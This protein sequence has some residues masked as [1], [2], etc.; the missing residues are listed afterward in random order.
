MDPDPQLDPSHLQALFSSG[1]HS[2]QRGDSV[3]A[4]E[5]L[6]TARLQAP[7][8]PMVP[9]T[10]G[11]VSSRVRAARPGGERDHRHF[12]DQSVLSARPAG[13]GRVLPEEPQVQGGGEGISGHFESP[14][15]E[16]QWPTALRLRLQ[17][18]RQAVRRDTE[19]LAEY[20]GDRV[21]GLSNELCN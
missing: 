6:E 14:P 11:R 5:L 18:A 7:R 9:L 10:I 21:S 2:F 20:L 3:G 16:S 4:L 17:R 1:V 15:P 8:E 12:G 13:Q 19:E